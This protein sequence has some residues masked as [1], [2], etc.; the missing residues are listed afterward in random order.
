MNR[1]LT[2]HLL[3]A[4]LGV[5]FTINLHAQSSTFTYQGQLTENGLP[6][7]GIYDLRFAIYDSEINGVEV[8]VLTNAATVVTAGRFTV[9]LDFGAGVFDGDERWLEIGAVTN[10]GG[11][12]ACSARVNRSRPPLSPSRRPMRRQ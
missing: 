10:G 6:A 8:S 12:S 11:C 7:S 2:H 3:A 5:A 9:T 4:L 1:Q